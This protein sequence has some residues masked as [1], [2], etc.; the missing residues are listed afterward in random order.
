[1]EWELLAGL[2]GADV[3]RVIGAARRRRFRKGEVVCH[4]GDPADTLHLVA[5]GHFAVRIETPLGDAA[6]LGVHGPGEAFGE[7]AVLREGSRRSATVTAIDGGETFALSR[8]AFDEL[9]REHPGVTRVLLAILA[10]RIR[11]RNERIVA[12]LYLDADDRVRWALLQLR[13]TY[14]DG[15]DAATYTVPLTQAELAGLAG[16]TR[17][18]LNKVLRAEAARGAVELERGRTTV[19][20]PDALARELTRLPQER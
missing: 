18:T 17:P 1:M 8:A 19:L 20:D 9:R 13:R 5:A 2:P 14:G 4:R 15:P 7:M 3:R 11:R 10:E 12:A 6:L 16:V